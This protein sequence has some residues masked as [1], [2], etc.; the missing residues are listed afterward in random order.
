M[1]NLVSSFLIAM[2]SGML[3]TNSAVPK[4]CIEAATLI[5]EIKPDYYSDDCSK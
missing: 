2:V 5:E 3:M 1:Y 4:I